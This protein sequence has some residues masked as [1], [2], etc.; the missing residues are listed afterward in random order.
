[1]SS[2]AYFYQRRLDGLYAIYASADRSLVLADINDRGDAANHILDLI[3]AD[4]QAAVRAELEA[5]LDDLIAEQQAH[6]AALDDHHA[7]AVA[8]AYGPAVSGRDA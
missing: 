2:P 3:E 6:N 4:R 7:Q 1:M 8:M 5:A